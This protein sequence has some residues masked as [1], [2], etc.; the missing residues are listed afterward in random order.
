L[1]A[2]IAVTVTSGRSAH[3][4]SASHEATSG[5][6]SGLPAI[7]RIVS[8]STMIAHVSLAVPGA[9][10]GSGA[11]GAGGGRGTIPG[12]ISARP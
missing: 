1:P 3:H 7:R 9:C 8:S 10:V 2:V 12:S 6:G 4:S 5:I 11:N